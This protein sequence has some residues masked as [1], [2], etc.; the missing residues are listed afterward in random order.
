MS[1]IW[2]KEI[3]EAIEETEYNEER[4]SFDDLFPEHE[5]DFD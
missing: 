4:R 3:M 5:E 1:E 2:I